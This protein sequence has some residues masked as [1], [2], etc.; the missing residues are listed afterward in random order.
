V[1]F[2]QLL[3]HPFGV[4]PGGVGSFAFLGTSQTL[5]L[6]GRNF[7]VESD[8]LLFALALGLPGIMV[9]GLL[10]RRIFRQV[11]SINGLARAERALYVGIIAG[12]A[13]ILFMGLASTPLATREA[14]MVFWLVVGALLARK[15]DHTVASRDV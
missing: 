7:Y 13:S 2:G 3:S 4:G 14:G 15:P 1:R 12:C 10:M 5:D 9:A 11:R 8:L 6:Q